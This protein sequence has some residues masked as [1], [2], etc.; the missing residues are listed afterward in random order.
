MR[1]ESASQL[2][3][4]CFKCGCFGHRGHQCENY[5][6]DGRYQNISAGGMLEKC[7]ICGCLGHI[8]VECKE[9]TV[10]CF[11]CGQ[12]GHKQEDCI[13][14]MA[15]CWNCGERGHIKKDCPLKKNVG[16]CFYC[17]QVGH[18]SK[19]CDQKVCYI[20][21][22]KDHLWTRCPLKGARGF[23]LRG[24][25]HMRRTRHFQNGQGYQKTF[26]RQH[27]SKQLLFD[28]QYYQSV[29]QQQQFPGCIRSKSVP[30][31]SAQSGTIAQDRQMPLRINSDPAGF[32][33]SFGS[34]IQHPQIA[35]R[36]L[37]YEMICNQSLTNDGCEGRSLRSHHDSSGF[38]S[39]GGLSRSD[40]SNMKATES[41]NE[42]V[43]HSMDTHH[44]NLIQSVLADW[45]KDISR[46]P[47]HGLPTLGSSEMWWNN[48]LRVGLNNLQARSQFSAQK[49]MLRVLGENNKVDP[50]CNK[51]RKD[52]G[53]NKILV[54]EDAQI[55]PVQD[56]QIL[57]PSPESDLKSLDVLDACEEEVEET[58][59][60]TLSN[61][62]NTNNLSPTASFMSTNDS[63]TNISISVTCS[64]KQKDCK[65]V[66]VDEFVPDTTPKRCNSRLSNAKLPEK[67]HRNG[68][69][70]ELK[71]VREQL[72]EANKK[73][74]E[75][76]EQLDKTH[77]MVE[78][79]KRV[80]LLDSSVKMKYCPKKQEQSTKDEDV[81]NRCQS[82]IQILKKLESCEK[83]MI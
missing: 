16:M 22:S 79:L 57:Q 28:S 46:E 52:C 12:R 40:E 31:S 30:L 78:A 35:Q 62:I 42:N 76:K 34:S 17:H 71:R 65:T 82:C 72:V 69:H 37:D 13:S 47:D 53:E 50:S 27:F 14:P 51:D 80:I 29:G 63:S 41:E 73:L 49:K 77:K 25:G 58:K 38:S 59:D 75:K 8:A 66:A 48:E 15:N 5:L 1:F 70:E 83:C 64:G 61:I 44:S 3:V 56:Q 24:N 81:S 2:S 6:V 10:T 43:V 4:R 20:C 11:S 67:I 55:I 60:G 18:H 36:M 19:D 68:V 45:K 39:L 9:K 23:Q 33:A 26:R 7:W 32:S 21:E 54:D 74:N